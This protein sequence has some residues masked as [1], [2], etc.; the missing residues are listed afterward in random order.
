[1]IPYVSETRADLDRED[2]E[3]IFAEHAPGLPILEATRPDEA[4][5]FFD[6]A[7]ASGL[8]CT[9][10]F[11]GHILDDEAQWVGQD[12][13]LKIVIEEA[14]PSRSGHML[15]M[16]AALLQGRQRTFDRVNSSSPP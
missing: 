8:E 10:V 14:I 5:H 11:G 15:A 6:P 1:V 7:V 9:P 3:S 2:L 13:D 12:I 4:A 16:S